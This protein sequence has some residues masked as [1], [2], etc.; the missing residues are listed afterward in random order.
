M[1]LLKPW[2]QHALHPGLHQ[3]PMPSDVVCVTNTH[4]HPGFIKLRQAGP[5]LLSLGQK[6]LSLFTQ[7]SL[8]VPNGLKVVCGCDV[9]ATFQGLPHVST[10]GYYRLMGSHKHLR[11]WQD[12]LQSHVRIRISLHS[13]RCRTQSDQDAQ[14]CLQVLISVICVI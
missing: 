9:V 14:Y 8:V 11:R 4:L 3:H 5:Q 13:C 6:C 1:L 2:N 12:E 10:C 7:E